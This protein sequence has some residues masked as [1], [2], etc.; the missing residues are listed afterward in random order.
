MFHLV[1]DN[2][3]EDSLASK[4]RR[5]RFRFFLDLLASV[6]K[7]VSILD[8]GGTQIFWE[9]MGFSELEQI[10]IT[11][12]NLE[13]PEIT[14]SN[15]VGLEGDAKNLDVIADQQFDVVF[16]NSV[17]EHVG[18]FSQQQRMASEIRRVG[19]R[20]FVQTPNCNFPMEPHYLFPAFQ[21]LPESFQVG[22]IRHFDLG[23]IK[24]IPD[25]QEARE[26]VRSIRL[27]K[28]NELL[29]LF[30]DCNIY[31]EKFLGLVKSYVVFNKDWH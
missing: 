28:K 12:L 4:M 27:I 20:Y 15:F 7:P 14:L 23:H 17:I 25:L 18:D 8:V 3:N 31:E 29:T 1:G 2:T 26:Q 19:K 10:Q 21:W 6:P 24:K 11:L 30:P 13:M 16:S 9:M 22:L 5:S